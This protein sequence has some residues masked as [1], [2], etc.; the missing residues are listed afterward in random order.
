MCSKMFCVCVFDYMGVEFNMR[1]CLVCFGMFGVL[2]VI[3]CKVV[4]YMVM[5]VLVLNCEIV[6]ETKFDCK[7]YL[8]FDLMKGY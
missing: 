2:L 8:Y 1:V 6:L 5:I 7:N 4:I 3:N